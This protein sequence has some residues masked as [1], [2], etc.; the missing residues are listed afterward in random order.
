VEDVFDKKGRQK[1][2]LSL[3]QLTADHKFYVRQVFAFSCHAL[4]DVAIG[5]CAPME[6]KRT[7]EPLYNKVL[8]IDPCRLYPGCP[9]W[10][11]AY[12]GTTV[13]HGDRQDI[14]ISPNFYV[15]EVAEY[16]ENGRDRSMLPAPCYRTTITL[17]AASSGGPV[18]GP[19][20][21]VVGVN[22]SSFWGTEDVSFISRI[23]DILPL[24][25]PGVKM[26]DEEDR[27]RVTIQELIEINHV[28]VRG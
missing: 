27:R 12:P 6:H 17:H 13:V 1:S 22:S 23:L 7:R 9:V 8:T 10:T 16:Y 20:S 26:L 3:L 19:S 24:G 18:F 28:A 21:A 2:G 14:R 11:Y 15:G 25:I 5:V 4:A